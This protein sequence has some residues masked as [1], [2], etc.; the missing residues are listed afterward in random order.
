MH[1]MQRTRLMMFVQ[2]TVCILCVLCFCMSKCIAMPYALHV[3]FC[4]EYTRY[5]DVY[6]CAGT[7]RTYL[8]MQT[9]THIEIARICEYGQACS[10]PLELVGL[11][12]FEV[13][14]KSEIHSICGSGLRQAGS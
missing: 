8:C 2:C 5:P 1:C 7:Q 4:I 11:R 10:F 6:A 9:H 14:F 13:L 3:P 12:M